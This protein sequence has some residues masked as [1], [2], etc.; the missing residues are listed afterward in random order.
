MVAGRSS[1]SGGELAQFSGLTPVRTNGEILVAAGLAAECGDAKEAPDKRKRR[2]N[3]VA[4]DALQLRIAA[5][6]T[7]G[8]KRITEGHEPGIKARLTISATPRINTEEAED[9]IHS[10]VAARASRTFVLANRAVHRGAGRPLD[11]ASG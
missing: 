7:V 8:V 4:R 1:V 3:V 10:G 9:V 5:Q 2:G 11:L 6:G